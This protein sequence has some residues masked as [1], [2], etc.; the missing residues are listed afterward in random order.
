MAVDK[1]AGLEDALFGHGTVVSS[2]ILP[3]MVGYAV[4]TPA[5]AHDPAAAQ[6]LLEKAG[7]KKVEGATYRTLP[8]DLLEAK[9]KAAGDAA[10]STTD[11]FSV[12]LK[13]VQHPELIRTAERL[14]QQLGAV[15][16]KVEI[17]V[18]DPGDLYAT[19]I[20]P[21]DYQML[22]TGA[23]LG[24]DPDPFP[25]WHS[26]Q[27]TGKG[28]NLALYASR[29]ADAALEAARDTTDELARADRYKE[30]QSLLAEDVPAV[31]LYQST[32]GYAPA[33]KLKNVE[34]PRIVTPADRFGRGNEG[35]IKTKK[36]LR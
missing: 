33:S 30:F 6:E 16:I 14:V 32:Y 11:E 34:I 8:K 26:S 3:G 1:A 15:G 12:I 9:K 23:L 21:R 25:F 35:Y 20:E 24:L 10:D 29:K 28:L 27:A 4:D 2:P 7:F 19:V 22:L 17:E 13:T 5:P 31:F 18:V 36:V